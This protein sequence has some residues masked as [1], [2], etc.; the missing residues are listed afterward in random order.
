MVEEGERR[1]EIFVH[2]YIEANPLRARKVKSLLELKNYKYS[3][4][5][6]YA[7]GVKNR[8]TKNLTSPLWYIDLGKSPLERQSAYRKLFEQFLDEKGWFGKAG[9]RVNSLRDM[10][11]S[12][13]IKKRKIYFNDVLKIKKANPKLSSEEVVRKYFKINTS[14]V[15]N[16]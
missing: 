12:V 10:G 15:K 9:E 1:G 14:E 13:F 11:N 8:F 3:S 16:E 4:F 6:Y 7:Y 2:M 5:G